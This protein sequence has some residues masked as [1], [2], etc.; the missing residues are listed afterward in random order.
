MEIEI[1]KNE[2][3]DLVRSLALLNRYVRGNVVAIHFLSE[4]DTARFAKL[5][6]DDAKKLMI[7]SRYLTGEDVGFEGCAKISIDSI[8]KELKK[9]PSFKEALK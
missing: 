2:R 3:I 8:V 5:V 4:E 9:D 1:T 7:L 6:Y